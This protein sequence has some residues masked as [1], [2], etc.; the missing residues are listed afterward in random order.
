MKPS[1]LNLL[2]RVRSIRSQLLLALSFII[3]YPTQALPLIAADIDIRYEARSG[4]MSIKAT[5]VTIA[6]L[7]AKLETGYQILLFVSDVPLDTKVTCDVQDKFIDDALRE[8]L[9]PSSHFFYRFKKGD[10]EVAD[11]RPEMKQAGTRMVAAAVKSGLKAQ[12]PATGI[13]AAPTLV[14]AKRTPRTNVTVAPATA[15]TMP[16]RPAITAVRAQQ[17]AQPLM[18]QSDDYFVKVVVKVTPNGYEPV[19]YTKVKGR[20]VE[21]STAGGDFIYQLKDNSRSVYTGSFQDPLALH[22]YSP[23]GKHEV[24]QAKEAYINI[25][26]PPQVLD[27]NAVKAP[28]LEFSKIRGEALPESRSIKS[29]QASA[30]Q[31]KGVI[32]A[33]A[34]Q[35]IMPRQ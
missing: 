33:D 20:L 17:L 4:K 31:R 22:A 2:T 14:T 26:L 24:L 3:L 34:L 8:A 35:K 28:S 23:D 18:Q 9:P 12:A 19:S 7:A 10:T 32:N 15:G 11:R 1:T 27:K 13:Q 21:D 5:D 29:I 25:T 6:E 30:L 16:L